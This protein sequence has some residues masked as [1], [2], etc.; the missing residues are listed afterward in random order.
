MR[1]AKFLEVVQNSAK[2]VQSDTISDICVLSSGGASRQVDP[3]PPEGFL[4]CGSPVHGAKKLRV[5]QESAKEVQSCTTPDIRLLSPGGA[6]RQVGPPFA[7]LLCV[8]QKF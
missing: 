8:V 7:T 4:V 2:G 1:G 5:V 3:P 6:I